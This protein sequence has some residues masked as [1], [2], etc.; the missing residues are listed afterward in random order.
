MTY[1]ITK[2]ITSGALKGCIVTEHTTTF[3]QPG[4]KTTYG[5]WTGPAYTVLA[6]EPH[7]AEASRRRRAIKR[8]LRQWGIQIPEEGM[9]NLRWLRAKRNSTETCRLQIGGINKY[10]PFPDLP[11]VHGIY[12]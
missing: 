6:C 10:F 2:E 5:A 7:T 12:F 8:Q 11:D 3:R 1:M 4:S 9:F